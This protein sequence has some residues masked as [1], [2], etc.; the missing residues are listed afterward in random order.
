VLHMLRQLMGDINFRKGIQAY[1]KKYF[2]INA[3]T[4]DFR[5][6]MELASGL[7]LQ[8]FFSQW[9]FQDGIPNL[10]AQW[11]WDS[12]KK[13]LKIT[14]DQTQPNLFSFPLEIAVISMGNLSLEVKKVNV[15]SKHAT[16]TFTFESKP[17]SVTLDPQT[18]LLSV[19][20]VSQRN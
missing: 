1:Y 12:K 18:K 16:F 13:E 5:N 8:P 7:D 11:A 9:L 17:V 10:K 20:D 19:F 14:L 6:E 2:N 4:T 3:T 15:L